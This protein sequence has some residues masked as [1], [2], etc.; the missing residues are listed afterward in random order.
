M[1]SL[2]VAQSMGEV[3]RPY[4]KDLPNYAWLHNTYFNYDLGRSHEALIS[5]QIGVSVSNQ[6]GIQESR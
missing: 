4:K 6:S 1:L 2:S 5:S 3:R